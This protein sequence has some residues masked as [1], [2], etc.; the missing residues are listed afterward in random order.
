MSEEG[1]SNP[2][3]CIVGRLRTDVEWH[4]RRGNMTIAKDCEEAADEIERLQREVRLLLN[5]GG[6]L[7]NCAFNLAQRNPGQ[8]TARDIETL[9]ASRLVWDAALR[10][11][12][13]PNAGAKRPAADAGG[14]NETTSG[15]S[16]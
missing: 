13:P 9:D 11:I 14:S 8:F 2:L 1:Q 16:A 4:N 3:E 7:S 5:A 6:A 15:G 10:M 12:Q